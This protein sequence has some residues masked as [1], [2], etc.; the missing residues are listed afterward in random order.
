MNNLETS[1]KNIIKNS[2]RFLR[3]NAFNYGGLEFK[4]KDDPVTDLDKNVERQLKEIGLQIKFEAS[5][6]KFIPKSVAKEYPLE[7][8]SLV[9]SYVNPLTTLSSW[10]KDGYNTFYAPLGDIGKHFPSNDSKWRNLSQRRF[11]IDIE[12][13]VF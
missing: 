13:A 3:D 4:E 8:S 1:I 11:Q 6:L 9:T 2:G 10:E 7:F 12:Y 5:S